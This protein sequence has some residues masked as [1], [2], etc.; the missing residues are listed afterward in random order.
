MSS[1]RQCRFDKIRPSPTQARGSL[2]CWDPQ[3]QQIVAQ[4]WL[5]SGPLAGAD[6]DCSQGH[7][8]SGLCSPLPVK[9]QRFLWGNFNHSSWFA[10]PVQ[11]IL[12]LLEREGSSERL[13]SA[14]NS[15]EGELLW[16]HTFTFVAN[17]FCICG[18]A[19]NVT[20]LYKHSGR[21]R[22]LV[23]I[24]LRLRCKSKHLDCGNLIA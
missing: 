2:W 15:F 16:R 14:A 17:T 19:E 7:W 1:G 12:L 8:D 4:G 13:N 3:W 21:H 9:R 24:S 20:L 23:A 6:W 11:E 22:C 10:V 18:L 5:K